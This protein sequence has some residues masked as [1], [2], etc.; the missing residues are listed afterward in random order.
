MYLRLESSAASLADSINQ[1]D[2][3]SVAPS[4]LEVCAMPL[5]HL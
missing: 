5:D 4:L 1:G 3:G 2:A